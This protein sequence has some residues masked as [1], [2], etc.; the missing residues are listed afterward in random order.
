ML[1]VNEYFDGNVKSIGLNNVDG[2]STVGVIAPGEYEF[3]TST[4]EYMHIV[5]GNLEALLPNTTEWKR[6]KKGE[7]FIVECCAKFKV[8]ATS[9]VAY[10]CIYE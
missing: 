8:R 3:G 9:D 4:K 6:F 5:S 7:H 2:K 10:L 1:Q